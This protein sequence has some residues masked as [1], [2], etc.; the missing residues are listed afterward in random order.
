MLEISMF[1]LRKT[2][3]HVLPAC[4]PRMPQDASEG[5][6]QVFPFPGQ[7]VCC[8]SWLRVQDG[9][10]L[11]GDPL[12]RGE[13]QEEQSVVMSWFIDIHCGYGRLMAHLWPTL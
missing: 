1:N 4:C 2:D 8:G 10:N 7:P 3:V 5:W 13:E 9:C 11:T 12:V 6:S